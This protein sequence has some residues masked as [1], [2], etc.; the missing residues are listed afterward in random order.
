[1][2]T[3]QL[4][5][6]GDAMRGVGLFHGDMVLFD[7]AKLP[8]SGRAWS[9]CMKGAQ[10]GSQGGGGSLAGPPIDLA[11]LPRDTNR[12]FS[13]LAQSLCYINSSRVLR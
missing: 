9:L 8:S 7:R 10:V 13:D 2:S 5:V 11:T 4:V 12:L 3:E 1:M 6:E